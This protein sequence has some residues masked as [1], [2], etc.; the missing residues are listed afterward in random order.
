MGRQLHGHALPVIDQM[1]NTAIQ[2]GV[3]LPFVMFDVNHAGHISAAAGG[4]ASPEFECDMRLAA[5]IFQHVGKA[6]EKFGFIKTFGRKVLHRKSGAEF[7]FVHNK[8]QLFSKRAGEV[9]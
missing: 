9:V 1:M 6:C 3:I 8:A 4:N 2:N 7:Q 5:Q